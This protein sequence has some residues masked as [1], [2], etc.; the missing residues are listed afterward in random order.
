MIRPAA[1]LALVAL[2]VLACDGLPGDWDSDPPPTPEP[3]FPSS[4]SCDRKEGGYLDMAGAFEL[5]HAAKT[6]NPEIVQYAPSGV[7]AYDGTW[8]EAFDALRQDYR[9]KVGWTERQMDYCEGR[10]HAALDP[11]GQ[12]AAAAE[13]LPHGLAGSVRIFG[14]VSWC[15][16]HGAPPFR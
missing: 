9:E 4:A 10:Y 1:L 11:V 16:E 15:L 13:A 14:T 3:G 5:L 2:A 12:C 6:G 7:P 8:A